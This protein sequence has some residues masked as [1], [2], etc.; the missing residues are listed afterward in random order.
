MIDMRSDN[1]Y[2]YTEDTA[3]LKQIWTNYTRAVA[4][5]E[6]KVDKT[7]LINITGLRDWARL[8]GGGYNAEGNAL[9]YK[10]S[11]LDSFNPHCLPAFS[12]DKRF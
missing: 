11:H 2:L 1:Y 6:G 4:F 12:V 8:G 3:W 7:G 9:L 10:V 5:L